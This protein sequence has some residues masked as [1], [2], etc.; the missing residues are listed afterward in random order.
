MNSHTNPP[1]TMEIQHGTITN[2]FGTMKGYKNPPGT[3]KTNLEQW[4]TMKLTWSC[5]GGYRKL[6]GGSA[7]FSWQ[8]HTNLIMI[9]IIIIQKKHI[10]TE[11]YGRLSTCAGLPPPWSARPLYVAILPWV[12]IRIWI[13][14]WFLI[15]IAIFWHPALSVTKN[16]NLAMLFHH[17]CNILLLI[18]WRKRMKFP[19]ELFGSG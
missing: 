14:P 13:W 4:K 19:S 7:H 2:R 15:I 18:K 3:M 8:T 16:L 1:G 10:K 6:Q 17:N 5:E 12:L 11:F 9:N